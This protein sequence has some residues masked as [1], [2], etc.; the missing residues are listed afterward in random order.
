MAASNEFGARIAKIVPS[1][2]GSNGI[3][4][5]LEKRQFAIRP[6][7]RPPGK[8]K[9]ARFASSAPGYVHADAPLCSGALYIAKG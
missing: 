1:G 5:Y 2:C 8:K 4:R 3:T 7:S 9:A 6:A